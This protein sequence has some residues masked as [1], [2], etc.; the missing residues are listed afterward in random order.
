MRRPP[1]ASANA[2]RYPR[3]MAA[4]LRDQM[5]VLLSVGASLVALGTSLVTIYLASTGR[6]Q[7]V[8][9][10]TNGSY[11]TQQTAQKLAVLS[12]VSASAAIFLLVMNGGGHTHKR[13]RIAVGLLLVCACGWDYL[14]LTSMVH[15]CT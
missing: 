7:C 1:V 14:L 4:R 13:T 2:R 3:C 5:H 6:L 9:P 8:A 15:L 12:L 11:A 10:W